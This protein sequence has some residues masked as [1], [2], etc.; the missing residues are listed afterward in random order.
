M[1]II[2]DLELDVGDRFRQMLELV[3]QIP[4]SCEVDK[5]EARIIKDVYFYERAMGDPLSQPIMPLTLPASTSLPSTSIYISRYAI[6]RAFQHDS[7]EASL[8]LIEMRHEYE[9]CGDR[10]GVAI[11]YMMEGDHAISP[12]YTSPIALNLA[13]QEL[14]EHTWEIKNQDITMAENPHAQSCWDEAHKIF[15]T[16]QSSRGQGA[17]HLRYACL[18][19]AKALRAKSSSDLEEM[20]AQIS[21]ATRWLTC[22]RRHFVKDLIHENIVDCHGLLLNITRNRLDDV[23]SDAGKIGTSVTNTGNETITDFLGL[24]MMRFGRL[25]F[26]H[27][28]DRCRALISIRAA[29]ACFTGG[30]RPFLQLQSLFHEIDLLDKNLAMRLLPQAFDLAKM[31]MHHYLRHK[32]GGQVQAI[33]LVLHN[34]TV[35]LNRHANNIYIAKSASDRLLQSGEE[36]RSFQSALSACQ[37]LI[38]DSSSTSSLL[39]TVQAGAG[40]ITLSLNSLTEAF[41]TSSQRVGRNLDDGEI[42]LYEAQVRD[43][44]ANAKLPIHELVLYDAVGDLNAARTILPAFTRRLTDNDISLLFLRSNQQ[45]ERLVTEKNSICDMAFLC[46]CVAQAWRESNEILDLIKSWHPEYLRLQPGRLDNKTWFQALPIAIALERT[47]VAES[48]Q[49]YLHARELLEMERGQIHSVDARRE[50]MSTIWTGELYSGLARLCF[51]LADVKEKDEAISPHGWGL[52]S[53]SWEDQSLIFL[54]YGRSRALLD[55]LIAQSTIESSTYKEWL[56]QSYLVR[57]TDALYLIPESQE[58][59]TFR[60]EIMTKLSRLQAD[61]DAIENRM[62]K[63]APFMTSI[64]P[65]FIPS[66]SRDQLCSSISPGVLVIYIQLSRQGMLSLC[67]DRTGIL[68]LKSSSRTDLETRRLVLRYLSLLNREKAAATTTADL[69][70]IAEDLSSQILAPFSEHIATHDHISIIPSQSLYL[71]PCSAL[72]W[73]DDFLFLN[74]SVSQLPS[75]SAL[76]FTS[77]NPRPESPCM[78]KTISQPFRKDAVKLPFAAVEAVAISR[79]AKGLVHAAEDLAP[80]D[81]KQL[82]ED[83]TIVHVSAH[84]Y[85]GKLSSWQSRI[86]LREN[87]NVLDI[88]RF[89]SQAM[90]IVFS[91][92]LNGTGSVTNGNDF[93]GFSHVILETGTQSFVG[94]LWNV[95]DL[96]TMLLMCLFYRELLSADRQTIALSLAKAQRHLHR[97]TRETTIAL[98]EEIRTTF[99]GA[100][101]DDQVPASILK[102][103]LAKKKLDYIIEDIEDGVSLY[104]D[105][106]FTHPFYC[107]PFIMVGRGDLC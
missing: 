96:A 23:E 103:N 34:M 53:K 37:D 81:I 12:N 5:V 55:M 57:Q 95:D 42:E 84:G 73:K 21:T 3:R 74:K 22:A 4:A 28:N 97:L 54:E 107:A 40:A 90:L 9:Q 33:D 16:E 26:K 30:S 19:H 91:A 24:L 63:E 6:E 92:C 100:L 85:K 45:T 79:L 10:I 101:E 83:T 2:S 69:A 80:E 49:W 48:M 32:A 102:N 89:R 76:Y 14:E 59:A 39:E 104:K 17:I 36:F 52:S 77:L 93:V 50:H 68:Q 82:L 43:L 1:A 56:D 58:K 38:Q 99:E 11:S 13:P 29:R 61:L 25:Y 7:E 94:A 18:A 51:R 65:K 31:N 47:D 60:T 70:N 41:V 75:L 98:L 71:F 27:F 86:A 8:L 66:L 88:C 44:A 78:V 64:L 46:C 87:L 35:E 67:I 15:L 106:D 105:C 62:C 20:E 72:L